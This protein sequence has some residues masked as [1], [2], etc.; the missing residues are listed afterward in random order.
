[1]LGSTSNSP[2]MNE[3]LDKVEPLGDAFIV[4]EATGFCMYI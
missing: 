3:F 2:D 1:M 4:M